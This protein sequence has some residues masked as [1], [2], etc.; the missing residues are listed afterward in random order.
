MGRAGTELANAATALLEH[1]A[2]PSFQV[3][4]YILAAGIRAG[5]PPMPPTSGGEDG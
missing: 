2:R 1:S 5:S 4:E 3:F